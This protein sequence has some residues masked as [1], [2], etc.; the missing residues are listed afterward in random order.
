MK[1]LS[2]SVCQSAQPCSLGVMLQNDMGLK[3]RASV[4]Q[5]GTDKAGDPSALNLR[6]CKA[7]A[8]L[9]FFSVCLRGFFT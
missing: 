7:G 8:T 5:Q 6:F 9:L 4:L 2:P 1:A 3:V